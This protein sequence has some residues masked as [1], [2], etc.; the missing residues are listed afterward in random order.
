MR[1]LRPPKKQFPGLGF[2]MYFTNATER[3]EGKSVLMSNLKTEVAV[4]FFKVKQLVI[5]CL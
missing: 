5:T 1:V 3:Q 2:S 4:G